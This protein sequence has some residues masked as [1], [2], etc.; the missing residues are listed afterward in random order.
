MMRS[1]SNYANPTVDAAGEPAAF[2][3]QTVLQPLDRAA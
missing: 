2:I 1:T 3:Q